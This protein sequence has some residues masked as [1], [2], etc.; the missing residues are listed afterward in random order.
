MTKRDEITLPEIVPMTEYAT[1]D[2]SSSRTKRL[3]LDREEHAWVH[4]WS[5]RSILDLDST[6]LW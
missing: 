5:G 4:A 6:A 3:T 1:K 2:K